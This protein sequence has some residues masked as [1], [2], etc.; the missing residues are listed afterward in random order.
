MLG[1]DMLKGI[2]RA[3]PLPDKPLAFTA[4]AEAASQQGQRC[5]ARGR[6]VVQVQA[7]PFH[8]TRRKSGPVRAKAATSM[9][10]VLPWQYPL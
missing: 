5:F 4:A 9:S 6:W 2:V 3:A 10:N 7:A 8:F 1:R